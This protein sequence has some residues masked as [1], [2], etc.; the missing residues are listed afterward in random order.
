[1]NDRFAG[2]CQ[3]GAV[4]YHCTAEPI[5]TL[6]CHCRDCQRATGSTHSAAFIVPQDSFQCSGELRFSQTVPAR[7][8]MA[9]RYFCVV[10]GSP[11][12]GQSE[13]TGLVVVNAVTL[14]DASWFKPAMN[15]FTSHAAP[16]VKLDPNTPHHAQM[17]T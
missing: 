11:M 10:C 6:N 14:D 5:G 15:I 3:C 16:W 9:R 12:Y 2:R 13:A 17:P 7:G 8:G 1:M 4:S